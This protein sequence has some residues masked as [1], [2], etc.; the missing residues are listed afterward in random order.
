MS[1]IT[2]WFYGTTTPAMPGHPDWTVTPVTPAALGD[3]AP[4]LD[5][6]DLADEHPDLIRW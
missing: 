3:G 1:T 2:A 4:A 5:L 6:P